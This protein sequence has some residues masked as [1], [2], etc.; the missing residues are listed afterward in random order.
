MNFFH[1]LK[2]I[3]MV[4]VIILVH[5][6]LA[7]CNNNVSHSKGTISKEVN[8]IITKQHNEPL[9]QAKEINLHQ[10]LKPYLEEYEPA[11][12]LS[13]NLQ[14]TNKLD[15]PKV[16][17]EDQKEI[18]S[19]KPDQ[20]KI[21]LVDPNTNIDNQ[22]NTPAANDLEEL[23]FLDIFLNHEKRAEVVQVTREKNQ[24]WLAKEFVVGLQLQT[25][26]DM[27]EGQFFGE[28]FIL[29]PQKYNPQVDLEKFSLNLTIPPEDMALKNIFSNNKNTE[30]TDSIFSLIWNY[31]LGFS[32][33][34]SAKKAI[35]N[36]HHRTILT[37]PKGYFSNSL[38]LDKE[39]ERPLQ[40]VR[41]E[42]SYTIDWPKFELLMTFGD[43]ASDAPNWSTHVASAGLK[44]QKSSIFNQGT[45]SYPTVD[46]IPALEK[47]GTAEIMLNNRNYFRKDLP[48]GRF[49]L[50]DI[51]LPPG[52][53]KGELIIRDENGIVSSV[54]FSY[55]ADREMLKPGLQQFS[56]NFGFL[57]Q[58]YLSQSFSYKGPFFALNHKIGIA[59]FMTLGLH[60]QWSNDVKLGSLEPRF[61]LWNFASTAFPLALSFREEGKG[62][63]IGNE[64]N[65]NIAD[66]SLR[67]KNMYFSPYYKPQ[68]SGL[69]TGKNG[70]FMSSVSARM[71]KDF[72]R[73][74][75]AHYQLYTSSFA[76]NS[77]LSLNQAIPVSKNISIDGN[78]NY[79]FSQQSFSCFALISISFA[80]RHSAGLIIDEQTKNNES[81][82]KTTANYR[83]HSDPQEQNR[84]FV[85]T[86]VGYGQDL[87]SE[88]VFGFNNKTLEATIG[89]KGDSSRQFAYNGTLGGALVFAK[90]NFFMTKSIENS[91]S[92]LRVPNRPGLKVYRDGGLFLGE[93]SKDGSL[94]ITDLN[95]Y[96]KASISFD[97]RELDPS[98]DTHEL[99][100][101]IVINPGIKTAHEIL[102]NARSIKHF[103]FRPRK[104]GDYLD[105]GTSLSINQAETFVG[106]DGSVYVELESDTAL[107]SGYDKNKSCKINIS[108][109]Q[110]KNDEYL[111]DLGDILCE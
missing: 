50:D 29:I 66:L 58:N 32:H 102:L 7:S 54:P 98:I 40:F 49:L 6:F 43:S 37:T 26:R 14:N 83:Y 104:N 42:T 35:L 30:K 69:K 108:L 41:L 80:N 47:Q 22:Q 76:V 28:N 109:P 67:F 3:H 53:H 90:N 52:A 77:V 59:K 84:Y 16:A 64:T 10:P 38:K 86:S 73:Y 100:K 4:L 60:G 2:T 70:I 11:E 39:L 17:S 45:L 1:R 23:L 36:T 105:F 111:I 12:N 94:L 91:F 51:K 92:I 25:I 89:A 88:G 57:R 61:R 68:S 81:T 13:K 106:H 62:Y 63:G 95:Q 79:N 74:T 56:Y 27:K 20:A 19:R 71:N 34:V 110:S 24:L 33:D 72:I 82:L 46:L 5:L 99:E 107:I 103:V 65:M 93:T 31:I 85:S 55:F 8:S 18:A 78:I 96:Q 75:S 44:I 15:V 9:N 87:F 48:M 21:T 97:T 101:T